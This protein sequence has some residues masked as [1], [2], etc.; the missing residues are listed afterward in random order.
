MAGNWSVFSRIMLS[1]PKALTYWADSLQRNTSLRRRATV[2]HSARLQP[3]VPTSS[4]HPPQLANPA[5][6]SFLNMSDKDPFADPTPRTSNE[7]TRSAGRQPRDTSSP[8]VVDKE[9]DALRKEIE[10]NRQE[11]GKIKAEIRDLNQE[12]AHYWVNLQHQDAL[13]PSQLLAE[14]RALN[15]SIED[16]CRDFSEM[17]TKRSRFARIKD[18][19]TMH[20]ANPGEFRRL[21]P[22]IGEGPSLY[23]SAERRARPLEDVV[24]YAVR[25]II[26]KELC[27]RIFDP[28][29]PSLYGIAADREIK[30][31]YDAIRRA[32]KSNT[33]RTPED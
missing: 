6:T 7:G 27:K 1:L 24:D 5:G 10:R 23:C 9:T 28:F 32:C 19:T 13:E 26:N 25:T 2:P 12:Y 3:P 18:P 17:V 20:I 30:R 22:G 4:T 33:G 21:L 31:T 8:P 29:H 15:R 16:L 14:F 11:E